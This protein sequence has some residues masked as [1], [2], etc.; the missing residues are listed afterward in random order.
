MEKNLGNE[1]KFVGHSCMLDLAVHYLNLYGTPDPDYPLGHI[2]SIYFDSPDCRAYEEKANGD[3]LKQK[4]RIRWYSRADGSVEPCLPVF[5]EIKSR[6]GAARRKRRRSVVVDGEW[7]TKTAL[8]H[9]SLCTF[10]HR[11]AAAMEEAV[12]LH[13]I[14]SLCISYERWRFV[15]AWTGTRLAVDHAIRADRVNT[16]L[17]PFCLPIRLSRTICEFKNESGEPPLWTEPLFQSGFR[18]RSFSKY[19]EC[20]NQ[21]QGGSFPYE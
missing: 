15:C 20:I 14:P 13:W 21:M 4:I 18:M 1:R 16:S 2:H 8:D 19:G 6:V 17:F 3:N 12:P 11:Q 5:I 9:P 7:M 10:L